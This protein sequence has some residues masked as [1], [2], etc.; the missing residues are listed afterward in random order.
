MINLDL[1]LKCGDSKPFPFQVKDDADPPVV[2]DLTG[3][4][5]RLAVKEEA[6]DLD[7]DALVYATSYLGGTIQ[8]TDAANG[9]FVWT[10]R[11]SDTADA[12][13]GCYPWDV[14][15]I[16]PGPALPDAEVGTVAVTAGSKVLTGTGTAFSNA[17]RGDLIKLTSANAENNFAVAIIDVASDTEIE[18]DYDGW[19]TESG[20]AIDSVTDSS[21]LINTPGC[22]ELTLE[23]DVTRG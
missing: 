3:A 14:E 6:D 11:K 19:A 5:I 10:P 20:L 9:R 2:V 7:A 23:A 12:D 22:G 13:P 15:V 8:I 17:K 18:V 21:G 16:R 4:V 1:T